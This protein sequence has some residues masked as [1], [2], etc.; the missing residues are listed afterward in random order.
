MSFS[1]P[2]EIGEKHVPIKTGVIEG[3]VEYLHTLKLY[4]SNKINEIIRLRYFKED[5]AII[6]NTYLPL[7]LFPDILNTNLEKSIYDTMIDIYKVNIDKHK[8]YVE[9]LLL[10]DDE[11]D[12]LKND[13]GET[14]VKTCNIDNTIEKLP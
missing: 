6:E 5:P 2:E 8:V 12:L 1:Y 11:D 9:P 7:H 13:S 14:T 10:N 4:N 3:P